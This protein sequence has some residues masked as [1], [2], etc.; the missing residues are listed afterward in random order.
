[1]LIEVI[2]TCQK[3]GYFILRLDFQHTTFISATSSTDRHMNKI[4]DWIRWFSSI[5]YSS[6]IL[7]FTLLIMVVCVYT[8]ALVITSILSERNYKT[9]ITQ[10]KNNSFLDIR[11]GM[12][13]QAKP[14]FNPYLRLY[15]ID[16]TSFVYIFSSK[17]AE[18][19]CNSTASINR[20]HIYIDAWW[21]HSF[22]I[23]LQTRLLLFYYKNNDCY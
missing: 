10:D 19:S 16:F 7:F 12:V 23:Q 5:L 18:I 3:Y 17:H 8:I 15:S 14:F 1:M 4:F 2:R 6:S 13:I 11:A 21:I 20:C 22:W 9:C